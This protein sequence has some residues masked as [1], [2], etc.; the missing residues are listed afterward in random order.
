MF[1]ILSL[2]AVL[3]LSISCSKTEKVTIISYNI[4]NSGAN[5][6]I[7]SWE[8][9]KNMTINMI[10][11]ENPDFICMQ[12]VKIDQL[13]FIYDELSDYDFLG[14]GRDDSVKKGE[15]MAIFFRN[16]KYKTLENGNFW[17]SETPEKVSLGWDGVCRRM[18]TWGHFQ[19]LRSGKTF[20]CF[21]THLDHIG[22]V[23]REESIKLILKKI[24]EITKNTREPVFLTG[25]FN[26]TIDNPIFTPIIGRMYQARET[27]PVTDYKFTYNNFGLGTENPSV[28]DHIFYLNAY[29]ISFETLDKSYGDGYISD[30]FPIKA[31]VKM[32]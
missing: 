7:N 8:N 2:A 15:I 3:V 30:H 18:V 21:N 28:I 9:R 14:V 6:G 24:N 17:L 5:D 27:S 12:E 4:R 20:Y 13:D 25:D 22:K 29:P 11:R 26:A 1:K 10:N 23:A 16:D 32:N 19:N 31:V